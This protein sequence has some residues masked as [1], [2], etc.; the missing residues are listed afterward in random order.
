MSQIPYPQ[1]HI[2]LGDLE[3]LYENNR[4]HARDL[5]GFVG[6]FLITGLVVVGLGVTQDYARDQLLI[7]VGGLLLL[8]AGLGFYFAYRRR[9]N[10]SA[11]AYEKG[12]LFTDQRNQR[13]AWRWD[14]ITEV[15]E[16]ITYQSSRMRIP[17][18][19]T[20]TIHKAGGDS[21]KLDQAIKNNRGL[22]LRIQNEISQRLL[23]QMIQRYQ[24]GE[25]LTFGPLLGFNRQGIVSKDNLLPWEH[26]DKIKFT[27]L[28][29]VQITQKGQNRPWSIV[30]HAK[31]A[32]YPI[33]KTLLP[34]V[35]ASNPA[36]M[37]PTLDA[38][39][40]NLPP[41][42]QSKPKPEGGIGNISAR[43]GMDVRILL[44]EGYTMKEIQGVV[45]GDYSLDELR[46]RKP[47]KTKRKK[48]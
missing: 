27:Q 12:F 16:T 5:L 21:L 10:V 19:W 24:T 18:W 7:V 17:R 35:I 15:Y 48:R 25:T 34:Q 11:A 36:T 2:E 45:R 28:G 1:Q 4:G 46:Q 42:A 22:A 47:R 20:Y 29:N 30:L 37:R 43:L 6:L 31:I 14:E 32:N 26:I 39:A 38:P 3:T 8:T 40:E 33:L 23:P 13:I 44:M 41:Q 9:L